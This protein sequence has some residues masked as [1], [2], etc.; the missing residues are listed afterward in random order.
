MRA[1]EAT[2]VITAAVHLVAVQAAI[3]HQEVL[4]AAAEAAVVPPIRIKETAK[5]S[6]YS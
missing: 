1:T 3:V 6:D 5:K 2:I 4:Q